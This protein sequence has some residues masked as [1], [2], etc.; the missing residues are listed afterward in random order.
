[1]K[2]QTAGITQINESVAQIDQTTKDNVEIAN[3]ILE[4]V[5]KKRF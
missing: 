5:K 3:N 1:I 2:E 4:D